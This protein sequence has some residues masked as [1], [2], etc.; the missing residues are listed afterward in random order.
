MTGRTKFDVAVVGAGPVG[1][2]T[3]L[4]F[5]RKGARVVLLEAD[6][7]ACR[8]FAGEWI[9]P[10]GVHV[11]DSLRAG[12]M[13]AASPRTGYGF[14]IVPDDGDGP[15]E[16]GYEN[17]VALS[18]EHGDIVEQLRTAALSDPN[19]ELRSNVRAL[20]ID[21]H[22][23]R[24][25]ERRQGRALDV[26]AGRIVG[27]DGRSS[28]VR[29]SLGIEDHGTLLSYMAGVELR[30]VR[31]PHEGFGHV[32]LGGPGPML[33]YR[34]GDDRV[35]GCLDV[36]IEHG[37]RSRSA[38]YLWEAFSPIFPPNMRD[39]FR[40]ALAQGPLSW[41]ANRFRPRTHFGKGHVALVGDAIG[42]THPMTALG[43]TNGFLD[44]QALAEC[45]TL[46]EYEAR[47]RAHVPEVLSNALYH[48]FRRDDRGAEGLR[49]SMMEVLRK[50]DGERR[51]T[52][53]IM[54]AEDE[55]KRTFGSAFL[56]MAS[57]AAVRAVKTS[58]RPGEVPDRLAEL[59]GW[60]QWPAAGLVPQRLVPRSLRARATATHPLLGIGLSGTPHA[61][62]GVDGERRSQVELDP[63][64][65]I[66]RASDRLLSDLEV[67]AQRYGTAPD[68]ELAL[69]AVRRVRAIVSGPMR[70][71]MAARMTLAWRRLSRE[72]LPRLLGLA[73]GTERDRWTLV[74]LSELVLL[75]V[76][77]DAQEP[78]VG[79]LEATRAILSCAAP[80]GALAVRPGAVPTLS[81]TETG[82]VALAALLRTRGSE[83]P[84]E[85]GA[86]AQGAVAAA[87][88]WVRS[89]ELKDGSFAPLGGE[90][91]AEAAASAI[92]VLCAASA[93]PSDPALRR[94][95][96]QLATAQSAD[97]SFGSA[98][99]TAAV[100][101][102]LLTAHVAMPDAVSAAARWLADAVTHGELDPRAD[103]PA[104]A[105]DL[106]S[107]LPREPRLSDESLPL[108]LHA[109]GAFAAARAARPAPRKGV[110]RGQA[111]A[112]ATAAS[113]ATA[114]SPIESASPAASAPAPVSF[115]PTAQKGA[116]P[117]SIAPADWAFAKKALAEVSR[118]F[119]RP[120]A[121]L[122][123]R[124]EVA[125]TL[126]YLLCRI[127]DTVEDHVAV[128][129]DVRDGLFA[130]FLGVLERDE[131]A[132]AFERGMQKIPGDDE[133]L[134]LARRLSIVMRI[135]DAQDAHTRAATVR[136][137]T[138]MARGM[139]LYAHRPKG[140]DGMV[141]LL[142][143][144][145]LERYCYYVAGTVGHFL[146]DLFVAELGARAT[147]ERTLA[148]REDAEDFAAGLQLVNILKDVTDD[149]ARGWS[150]VPRT[151]CD[152]QSISVPELVD[153]SRRSDAHAAVAPLFDVAR[154]KLEGALRYTL[155]IPP[156]EHGIRLF[157]LLPLWMAART[158]VLARGN[159]AMF[160]AGMPV[161]ISRDE[162]E[163]IVAECV[164]HASDDEWIRA[165]WA[166]VWA[167]GAEPARARAAVTA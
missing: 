85:L 77:R 2:V 93:P 122:P 44:A 133:E 107:E 21:G 82:T 45:E 62:R 20:G 35:R 142:T 115:R 51:R 1:C 48:C 136:W 147:P 125:V 8:R 106:E 65:A 127:A 97:G 102:A 23:V 119:A 120:I 18:A 103:A 134:S 49:A 159:D 104:T 10:A 116:T 38:G 130:D 78:I 24:T 3:A 98:A 39:A 67:L 52:L 66:E 123:D 152:A 15:I 143:T 56:R 63:T 57:H 83:L 34:I 54:A 167:G 154:R 31:L 144:T 117:P 96:R 25:E 92:G 94:A 11:L 160:V 43:M 110:A 37:A 58:P 86:R 14:V 9:H 112:E 72:G 166:T 70:A 29:Q 71:G 87:D 7:R 46:A 69:P 5:A 108:A 101:R 30:G 129:A 73:S 124:L 80:S 50:D 111:S 146:T 33:L 158:L 132:S 12:R 22:V 55:G 91:A 126:G 81:A 64:P 155:S 164:A 28:V 47:R 150:F 74:D 139:A 75:L 41:A 90:S 135:F 17:G 13:D 36:P 137:V 76:E 26:E 89:L 148:L 6:P 145:D 95:C 118:T 138:E 68:H 27:A 59:V 140:D 4:A 16:M 40:A 53:R 156:E 113:S 19:V 121:L 99:Q 165:R 105:V 157:C 32:V 128:G 84:V 114:S 163:S 109:L 149:R 42:H 162:V 131:D 153:P 151:A 88:A 79:L 60:M 161:K 141:A 61:A 100:L